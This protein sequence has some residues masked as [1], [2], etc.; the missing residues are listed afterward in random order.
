MLLVKEGIGRVH[1]N[2]N[3]VVGVDEGR[4]GEASCDAIAEIGERGR[5]GLAVIASRAAVAVVAV[6]GQEPLELLMEEAAGG[7]PVPV[8]QGLGYT[9][10]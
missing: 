7:G 5:R 9:A 10:W 2:I 4:R 1:V 8:Q 3:A 6:F